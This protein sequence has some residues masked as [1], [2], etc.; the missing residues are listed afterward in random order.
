MDSPVYQ[1]VNNIVR[2]TLCM[3]LL[4][5]AAFG[6]E[7]PKS[8]PWVTKYRDGIEQAKSEKK[9]I[10]IDFMAEWCGWCKRLDEEVY[11]D[12]S[13]VDAL[14]EFVCIKVD[15]ESEPEVAL[16]YDVQ[17]LPRTVVINVNGEIVGDQVGYAPLGPFLEFV[18]GLKNDLHRR[19][20][21]AKMPEVKARKPAQAGQTG[22]A[23]AAPS[24]PV[25]AK[26][27]D[28]LVAQL[29][30]PEVEER[31]AAARVI[32]QRPNGNRLLVATLE[33]DYL[34][35]RVSALE[36]LKKAG[37]PDLAF[38]PWAPKSERET[39]LTAWKQWAEQQDAVRTAP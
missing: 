14:K 19:T 28:E 4:G 17:S 33:S 30:A 39:A 22:G 29:A 6:A 18:S 1:A 24:K 20:G 9:P 7:A 16:A 3:L 34:G 11:A 25:E 38:D 36:V 12:K 23:A 31:A 5:C 37:A 8:I 15:V 26:S 35:A 10:L 13:A 27:D 21:G 32:V 2:G